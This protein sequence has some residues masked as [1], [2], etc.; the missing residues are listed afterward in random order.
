MG[1]LLFALAVCPKVNAVRHYRRFSEMAALCANEGTWTVCCLRRQ[2]AESCP[3]AAVP[4]HR[5]FSE[6]AA[7]CDVPISLVL[8][9]QATTIK[10]ALPTMAISFPKLNPTL[11]IVNALFQMASILP[12]AHR[13]HIPRNAHPTASMPR[14]AFS[15]PPRAHSIP[16]SPLSHH[17]HPVPGQ[18]VVHAGSLQN[19]VVSNWHHLLVPPIHE[20]MHEHSPMCLH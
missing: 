14:G 1:R 6:M 13:D 15:P 11:V 20:H 7:L 18:P 12:L 10:W 8:C 19:D 4:H 9:T 2:F 5:R 17:Q 3:Q 16:P